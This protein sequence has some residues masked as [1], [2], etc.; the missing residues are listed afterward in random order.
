[1]AKKEVDPFT[2]EDV[3]S[4]VDACETREETL[5]M[6]FLPE[7]GCRENEMLRFTPEWIDW[8]EWKYGSITVPVKATSGAKPKTKKIK[9]IPMSKTLREVLIDIV[10]DK[11]WA[12]DMRTRGD[13]VRV[14]GTRYVP[15]DAII[16]RSPQH[17]WNVV[18]RVAKRAGITK[19]VYPHLFRHYYITRCYY[20]GKLEPNEIAELAG[21]AGPEMVNSVYLHIDSEKTNTKLEDSGFLE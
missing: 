11:E 6:C 9:K 5:I 1:M 20:E 3:S 15:K 12:K 13:A 2:K 14:R 18:R 4:M 21:H 17:I 19:R 8:G 7:T 10:N 16:V